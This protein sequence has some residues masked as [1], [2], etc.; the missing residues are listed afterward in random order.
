M[1][2]SLNTTSTTETI[3][4][5]ISEKR[6]PITTL[7][8]F[9]VPLIILLINIVALFFGAY[10]PYL[11][12]AM[13]I[14]LIANPLIRMNFHY[15][16]EDK[17]FF[18]KQGVISKKQRNLPYGVIQDISLKQDLFDRI[19]KIA[20]LR[21]ENASNSKAKNYGTFRF[22]GV[23][24]SNDNSLGVSGSKINIPGLKIQDAEELKKIILQKMKDNPI[25][26]SN[27]GL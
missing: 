24:N 15:S 18:V 10:Y 3:T 23:A 22:G 20:T 26:D 6:F 8:V 4:D 27:S 2:N 14:M 19:F 11:V 16:L 25:E 7:W 17:F 21:V 5:K 1:E 12:L 13:L 9:K